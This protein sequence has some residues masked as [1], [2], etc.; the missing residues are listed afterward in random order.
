MTEW[1]LFKDHNI[2][3]EP[4]T[5][6]FDVP[7]NTMYVGLV[8]IFYIIEEVCSLSGTKM[9]VMDVWQC[10]LGEIVHTVHTYRLSNGVY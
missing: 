2:K 5:Q 7:N 9:V 3:R 8:Y 6:A 1:W 4:H 10:Y